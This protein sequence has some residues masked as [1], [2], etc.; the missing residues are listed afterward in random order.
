MDVINFFSAAQNESLAPPEDENKTKIT[1]KETENQQVL[2]L[3]KRITAFITTVVAALCIASIIL[4]IW[5][6][7]DIREGII[8]AAGIVGLIVAPSVMVKQF[9]LLRTDSLRSAHNKIR[10]EINRFMEENNV[11]KI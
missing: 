11:S 5:S 9:I 3:A 2:T 10:M 4:E 6:I 7:Y 1:K 8:Y